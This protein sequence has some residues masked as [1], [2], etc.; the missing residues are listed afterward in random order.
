MPVPEAFD[1]ENPAVARV[2]FPGIHRVD[3]DAAADA[4]VIVLIFARGMS[5]GTNA[6]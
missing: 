1:G 2:L 4:E 5:I 6:V 3:Y